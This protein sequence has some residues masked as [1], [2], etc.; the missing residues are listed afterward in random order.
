MGSQ[1]FRLACSVLFLDLDFW[2][3][4]GIGL[5]FKVLDQDRIRKLG[6]NRSNATCFEFFFVLDYY[7]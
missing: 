1:R 6:L 3:W 7:I 2:T 5:D 4:K